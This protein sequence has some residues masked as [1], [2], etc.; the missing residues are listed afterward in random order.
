[1]DRD[2]T[3]YIRSGRGKIAALNPD[4]SRK[5]AQNLGH[6]LL[7]TQSVGQDG[8]IYIGGYENF[9]ALN[10][11]GTL[12]WKYPAREIISN[13]VIGSDGIIYVAGYLEGSQYL[14]AFTSNGGIKWKHLIFKTYIHYDCFG[15]KCTMYIF[16]S[17]A[18]GGDGTIYIA[19]FG[20][21]F[22]FAPDVSISVE[23]PDMP[24]LF[25]RL[26]NYPNP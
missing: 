1:M 14:I 8:T 18:I 23:S 24:I 22:A 26:Q 7:H 11:D 15:S 2:G 9:F 10:P 19:T 13:P 20:N 25:Y 3:I 17:P 21:L 4:G 6:I 16:S 12:K 5:W